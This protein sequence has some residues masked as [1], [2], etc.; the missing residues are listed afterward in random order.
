MSKGLSDYFV[1][2]HPVCPNLN[3]FDENIAYIYGS[4][5]NENKFSHI[6]RW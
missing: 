4:E 6:V 5:S 2:P 3:H 1:V